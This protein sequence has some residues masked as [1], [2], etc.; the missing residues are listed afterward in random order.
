[1]VKVNDIIEIFES[2]APASLAYSWDNTGL[3]CGD[4][5]K[6]VNKVFLTLDVTTET[7]NEAA[8]LNSDMI[9]SHHPI[10]FNGI[11]KIDYTSPEGYIIKTLLENNIALYAAH[12]SIDNACGGINDVLA[13]KLEITDT[14]IIEKSEIFEGCGLG[15]IGKL[16][17]EMKLKE[18]ALLVKEKLDTP[19]VRVCG[20]LEKTIK[21]AAVGSGACDNLIEPA[22]KMGADVM[23][24]SDMKY[25]I[26]IESVEKG[27]CVIDAGHFPT[28]NFVKDIFEDLLKD[29]GITI[30][31]SNQK[32]IFNIV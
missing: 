20:D 9:I 29:T 18:F 26:S 15:R 14:Q 10:M 21:F 22:L 5:D 8:K 12:T 1:M 13:Q 24:T 31:K 32:D 4:T 6:E 27:I 11:K 17:K 2:K 28:E 23:V 3:I 19:F 16:K 25:H 30:Y 7:V